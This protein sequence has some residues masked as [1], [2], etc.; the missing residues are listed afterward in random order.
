MEGKGFHGN[1]VEKVLFENRK[2]TGFSQKAVFKA[3]T[4]N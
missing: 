4:E 2:R 1:F 3:E